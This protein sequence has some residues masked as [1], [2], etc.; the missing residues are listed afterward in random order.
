MNKELD[1]VEFQELKELQ[2]EQFQMEQELME[3][4]EQIRTANEEEKIA[5][6]EKH[7]SL[8]ENLDKIY[9]EINEI[10]AGDSFVADEFEEDENEN[11]NLEAMNSTQ[12]LNNDI[13]G[14]TN[15]LDVETT[16]STNPIE[17]NNSSDLTIEPIE[18][19]SSNNSNQS[20]NS[21]ENNK[22]I[23]ENLPSNIEVEMVDLSDVP[24]REKQKSYQNQPLTS[25]NDQKLQSDIGNTKIDLIDDLL[26]NETNNDSNKFEILNDEPL[27]KRRHLHFSTPSDSKEESQVPTTRQLNELKANL[28]N[29]EKLDE[30][31]ESNDI[32]WLNSIK[33]DLKKADEE[34][35][36]NS[37]NMR[38]YVQTQRKVMNELNSSQ[39]NWTKPND[40]LKDKGYS[41]S[42]ES[43]KNATKERD[44]LNKDISF[45][46][47][48]DGMVD[49]TFNQ[50][51][52]LAPITPIV[53]QNKTS[54]QKR[55]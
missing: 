47:N 8:I 36:K 46:Q 33:A 2:S 26:E 11:E 37:K 22:D 51:T 31:E 18:I 45:G 44:N 23:Y 30:I 14:S 28:S 53:N 50:D 1:N 19:F 27:P 25:G 42:D 35:R 32:D 34:F 43:L 12:S 48:E 24:N 54:N 6:N 52:S 41:F 49:G 4:E 39:N 55:K 40:E 9:Q 17:F 29:Q 5:L 15:D 20:I 21:L 3:V 10:I 7:T 16:L 13:F 38:Q